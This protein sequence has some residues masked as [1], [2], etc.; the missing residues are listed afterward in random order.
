[1]APQSHIRVS[2]QERDIVATILRE[3]VAAG[4]LTPEEFEQRV[5]SAVHATFV[6]DLEHLVQDL[7]ISLGDRLRGPGSEPLEKGPSRP[8]REWL[9]S[10]GPGR[11][12]RN[13]RLHEQWLRWVVTNVVCL[14]IWVGITLANGEMTYFWPAWVFGPWGAILLARQVLRAVRT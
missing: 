1:M 4:R 12:P 9:P 13:A 11:A 7:P 14:T 2:D 10:G 6:A 3:H 5:D 8:R